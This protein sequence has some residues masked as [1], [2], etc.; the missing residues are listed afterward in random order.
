MKKIKAL[1]RE[2][3]TKKRRAGIE[4]YVLHFKEYTVQKVIARTLKGERMQMSDLYL[5]LAEHG[6]RWNGV[7]WNR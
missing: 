3:M 1:P 7:W 5:W 6:Y 2:M 4:T